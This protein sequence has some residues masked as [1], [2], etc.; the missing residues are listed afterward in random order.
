MVDLLEKYDTK[1]YEYQNYILSRL[2]D[3][4]K[5]KVY[6]DLGIYIQKDFNFNEDLDLDQQF[7]NSS[8]LRSSHK[9][10]NIRS[11]K[12]L[13]IQNEIQKSQEI[14]QNLL[15][16]KVYDGSTINHY[17]TLSTYYDKNSYKYWKT[18]AMFNYKYYKFIFYDK[19]LIK[20][21]IILLNV[22]LIL[23]NY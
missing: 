20:E 21:K 1:S 14:S 22:K 4:I 5:S 6:G 3:K 7:N 9:N 18:Y 8:F 15:S 10:F 17:L 19:Q 12:T 23:I 16:K 11:L 2:D 13:N